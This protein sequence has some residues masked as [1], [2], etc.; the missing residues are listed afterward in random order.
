MHIREKIVLCKQGG[1]QFSE[2]GGNLKLVV[3]LSFIEK[4]I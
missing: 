2:V 3:K 4:G 1:D